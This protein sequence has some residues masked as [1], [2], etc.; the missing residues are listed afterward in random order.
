MP[1]NRVELGVSSVVDIVKVA[2]GRFLCSVILFVA[3]AFALA[4]AFSAQAANKV[5]GPPHLRTA[6]WPGEW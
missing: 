2:S 3:L 6:G 4:C 1:D 5:I